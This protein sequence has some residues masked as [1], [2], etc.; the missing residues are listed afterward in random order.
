MVS[1]LVCGCTGRSLDK[2]TDISEECYLRCNE[3]QWTVSP[4][5]KIDLCQESYLGLT[6]HDPL[7]VRNFYVQTILFGYFFLHFYCWHYCRY[8]YFPPLP[9][10]S[11]QSPHPFPLPSLHCCLCLWVVHISSL[12]TSFTFFHQLTSSHALPSDSSQALPCLLVSVS[13]LFIS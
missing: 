10:C 11:S 1:A 6:C 4:K 3:R 5:V 13:I 12:A 9:I 2:M 8:P 7:L